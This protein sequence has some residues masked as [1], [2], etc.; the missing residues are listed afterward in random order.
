[1][2]PRDIYARLDV[3]LQR[4]FPDDPNDPVTSWGQ[5]NY[6]VDLYRLACD[7]Y[8][9]QTADEIQRYIRDEWGRNRKRAIGQNDQE[10]LHEIVTSW[11]AWQFGLRVQS[12]Y[13]DKLKESQ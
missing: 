11:D 12:G 7:A 6:K 3:L 4:H 5:P 2:T 9:I 13:F 10:Q 1:M 8:E